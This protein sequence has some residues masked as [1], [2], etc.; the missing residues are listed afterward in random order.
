[1]KDG[2][3]RLNIWV[4]LIPSGLLALILALGVVFSLLLENENE[5]SIDRRA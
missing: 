1:M 5:F 4:E 3:I 2:V